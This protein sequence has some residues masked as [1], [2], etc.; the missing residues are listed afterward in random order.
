MW[1]ISPLNLREP[2]AYV[3]CIHFTGDGFL[4]F[5]GMKG[6]SSPSEYA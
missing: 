6:D 4:I 1:N 5:G 2:L 3:G